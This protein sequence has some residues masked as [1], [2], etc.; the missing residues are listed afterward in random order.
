MAFVRGS[1]RPAPS[2][3]RVA[4][5]GSCHAGAIPVPVYGGRTH[6][7]NAP[8]LAGGMYLTDAVAARGFGDMTKFYTRP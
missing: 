2:I 1:V 6:T 5:D 4:V 3:V 8:A 7:S